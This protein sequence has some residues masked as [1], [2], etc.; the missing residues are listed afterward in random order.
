MS[1]VICFMEKDNSEVDAYIKAH[2]DDMIHFY[3]D[4]YAS[5]EGNMFFAFGEMLSICLEAPDAV[6]LITD[7]RKLGEGLYD[8]AFPMISNLIIT[9]EESDVGDWENIDI[10][11]A[12]D[13]E[14]KVM[15]GSFKYELPKR[16]IDTLSEN[17]IYKCFDVV[18]DLSIDLDGNNK[19]FE[20]EWI[21]RFYRHFMRMINR[22]DISETMKLNV[23]SFLMKSE[24]DTELAKEYL[25]MVINSPDYNGINYY[26]VWNQ[27]K[28]ISFT[29]VIEEDEECLRLLDKM[30]SDAH[31]T[32]YGLTKPLFNGGK[33]KNRNKDVVVVL[34]I[35]LLNE[36][37]AP[38]RTTMERVADLVKMGKK[39]YLV[40]TAEQYTVRGYTPLYSF[41]TPLYNEE[42][43]K[44][45]GIKVYGTEDEVEFMQLGNVEPITD[46]INSVVQL[47]KRVK[48]EY[49][50]SIGS[51][52]MVADMISNII[53]VASMAL[54]FS[55][56]PK[57]IGPMRIIGSEE[58]PDEVD[59]I[60]SRFTFNIKKPDAPN[61]DIS[62]EVLK[63]PNDRFNIVIIGIRLDNELDSEFLEV[64][65][66]VCQN[67]CFVTFAGILDTYK[68]LVEPY[69]SLKNNSRFIGYCNDILNLIGI[70]D[71]YVNP[72][73]S[74]GGYS[75]IEA[76][77]MGKPAVYLNK[78]D[79]GV[80][81]GLEFAVDNLDQMKE[82]ILRYKDNPD[83]YQT[84][85]DK[86]VK[87][88]EYMTDS[89]SAMRMLDERIKERI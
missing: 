75:V 59:V 68:M 83:Y 29:K 56:I 73:R 26:F 89:L 51:G 72:I 30:Y 66:S 53:P 54:V 37:H 6:A 85:S 44:I 71:L 38:S 4:I 76:F 24:L 9:S 78:G 5:C 63:I 18:A 12:L 25:R 19:I 50:L 49:V 64:L 23:L 21:N 70:S 62:R 39:V 1:T 88:A 52:S 82:T 84:M 33:L 36:T 3:T 87:R 17:D 32:F 80:A 79:V 13:Y 55:S 69:E 35:Q 20:K 40:N 57:A 7:D 60:P 10:A 74:G 16:I 11:T 77:T 43:S 8:Y 31:D 15:E 48:P 67:G 41:F 81:G 46:R 34:T 61:P 58:T 28:R 47:I 42:L 2:E 27:F 65:D 45:T 14:T 86:A 22:L